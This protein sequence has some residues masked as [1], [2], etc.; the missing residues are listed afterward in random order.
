MCC[1]CCVTYISIHGPVV[2]FELADVM[3]RGTLHL[4]DFQQQLVL[5]WLIGAWSGRV[6]QSARGNIQPYAKQR[7]CLA[8]FQR[9]TCIGGKVVNRFSGKSTKRDT[10]SFWIT[11]LCFRHHATDTSPHREVETFTLRRRVS[12]RCTGRG[13]RKTMLFSVT[14]HC[15]KKKKMKIPHKAD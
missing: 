1:S 2:V 10:L 13:W 3:L 4:V 5:L 6:K 11:A 9:E 15:K 14:G 8:Y 7:L 12:A